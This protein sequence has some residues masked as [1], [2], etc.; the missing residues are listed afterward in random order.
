[1]NIIPS[2]GKIEYNLS[3]D[4]ICKHTIQCKYGSRCGNSE[5]Q[6]Y[7]IKTSKMF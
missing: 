1:M 3:E 5:E 2:E 6:A 7:C 4:E